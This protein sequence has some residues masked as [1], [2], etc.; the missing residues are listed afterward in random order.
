MTEAFRDKDPSND[1]LDFIAPEGVILSVEEIVQKLQTELPEDKDPMSHLGEVLRDLPKHESWQSPDVAGRYTYSRSVHIVFGAAMALS[2]SSGISTENFCQRLR[3]IPTTPED[4][5]PWLGDV[6][7]VDATHWAV[8]RLK[9]DGPE[10]VASA[11]PLVEFLANY[12]S[13]GEDP[14]VKRAV[15]QADPANRAPFE[16]EEDS[17][18]AENITKLRQATNIIRRFWTDGTEEYSQIGAIAEDISQ[19]DPDLAAAL[20]IR[21][22]TALLEVAPNNQHADSAKLVMDSLLREA[23]TSPNFAEQSIIVEDAI[24]EEVERRLRGIQDAYGLDYPSDFSDRELA[25]TIT[26]ANG[27]VSE[28]EAILKV[29]GTHGTGFKPKYDYAVGK[30]DGVIQEVSFEDWVVNNPNLNL[31]QKAMAILSGT[32]EGGSLHKIDFDRCREVLS[33]IEIKESQRRHIL[34]ELGIDLNEA[35][36]KIGSIYNHP[37]TLHLEYNK[38]AVS[39]RDGYADLILWPSEDEIHAVLDKNPKDWREL[40]RDTFYEQIVS[41][42]RLTSVVDYIHKMAGVS[43]RPE[44]LRVDPI[45]GSLKIESNILSVTLMNAFIDEDG[46]NVKFV[47]PV[48]TKVSKRGGHQSLRVGRATIKPSDS[49]SQD[50]VTTVYARLHKLSQ[51]IPSASRPA[52][53]W[54]GGDVEATAD[55]THGKSKAFLE[56]LSRR[57]R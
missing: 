49:A 36:L 27:E 25:G 52:K 17:L 42:K 39:G 13:P 16:P 55:I 4:P 2:K 15:Y 45:N 28:L 32:S 10:D 26:D 48:S 46:T 43:Y 9:M 29:I 21:A 41:D 6:S 22:A 8:L 7:P 14:N 56:E 38:K 47:F 35:P 37:P 51:G 23:T 40:L 54:R 50:E 20:T 57:R 19:S 44:E 31:D 5:I 18:A 24:A 53:G 1:A 11:F 33:N 3:E 30:L 12:V 34:R